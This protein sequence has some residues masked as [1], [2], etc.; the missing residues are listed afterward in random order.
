MSAYETYATAALEEESAA[1][2]P[3]S[4]NNPVRQE[5]NRNLGTV[6]GG[7]T[8]KTDR[9]ELSKRGLTLIDESNHELDPIQDRGGRVDESIAAM[10]GQIGLLNGV[11]SRG[12]L[13]RIVSLAKRR[14]D[15]VSDIRALTVKANYETEK[16]FQ[17]IIQEKGNLPPSFVNELNAE[18]P[19]V[20]EQYNKRTALYSELQE[21]SDKIV[22]EYLALSVLGLPIGGK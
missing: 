3:A 6:L 8:S 21:I 15:M 1:Y 17:R 11:S 5:L 4:P 12:A 18:I 10:E 2:A 22:E 13:G 16:I 9:L 20:E 14:A 7:N 19:E